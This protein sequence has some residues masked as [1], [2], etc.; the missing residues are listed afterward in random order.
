MFVEEA[1][2]IKARL[3]ELPLASGA[4]VLDIG[5]STLEYR[6]VRQPHITELVHRPLLER[7]CTLTCGDIKAGEGVDLVVD[8]SRADL[9]EATFAR[10]Y[11]L[12]ICSNILEHI[13]DRETFMAN[14][15]R[16]CAKPGYLLCTVPH[17][18]P[19]HA[20]PIDTM[21]RPGTSE[22]A[23]FIQQR[24]PATVDG[25][26]EAAAVVRI[27]EEAYYRFQ[28][29]RI[30]D[31]LLLRALRARIRWHLAPLR[32]KVSCVLMRTRLPPSAAR[33]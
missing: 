13:V 18:F 5:S 19:H 27:D 14:V 31:H 3:A 12:V 33:S 26:V 1:K 29:G 20:D 2:W 28:P 16:F 4:R 22:L 8:L 30:L 17:A 23:R 9:P 6:T 15:L 25:A 24:S 7:G 21:Y 10:P 32:Y 11:D